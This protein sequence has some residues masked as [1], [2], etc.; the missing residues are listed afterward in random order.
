MWPL[1]GL[2]YV[3]VPHTPRA[4]FISTAAGPAVNL[5]LCILCTLLLLVIY[6]TPIQPYWV[7]VQRRHNG[8]INDAG[9][10]PP[11]HLEQRQLR[12]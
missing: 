8:R 12:P 5:F 2:A 9:R 7:V 3:D 11:L 4:N 10:S 6:S 1:G